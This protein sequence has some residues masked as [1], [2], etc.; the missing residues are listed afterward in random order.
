M[1]GPL[2]SDDIDRL[3]DLDDEHELLD[4]LDP[5]DIEQQHSPDFVI[6]D[7]ALEE[8][9]GIDSDI[10]TEELDMLDILRDNGIGQ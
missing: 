6:S 10:D 3:L 1:S 9:F 5:D 2:N 7:R 4:L 8:I